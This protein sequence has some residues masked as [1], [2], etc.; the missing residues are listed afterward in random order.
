MRRL[1]GVGGGGIAQRCGDDVVGHLGD[2]E[3]QVEHLARRA[4]RADR[5][6]LV[7]FGGRI[8][9]ETKGLADLLLRHL[10]QVLGVFASIRSEWI[11][12]HDEEVLSH[13]VLAILQLEEL[14]LLRLVSLSVQPQRSCSSRWFPCYHNGFGRPASLC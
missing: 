10:L 13:E 1:D 11:T 5:S 3:Q 14:L 4:D 9:D 6:L 12:D 2:G 8:G 7:Q